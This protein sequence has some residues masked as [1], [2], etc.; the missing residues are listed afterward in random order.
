[1]KEFSFAEKE[2]R[3]DLASKRFQM[4]QKSEC[5]APLTYHH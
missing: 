1:M 3:S 5:L 4:R 2:K